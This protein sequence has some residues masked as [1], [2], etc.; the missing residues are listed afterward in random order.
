MVIGKIT[1][2]AIEQISA[3]PIDV[4]KMDCETLK[5][6]TI[7]VNRYMKTAIETF[8]DDPKSPTDYDKGMTLLITLND[9]SELLWVFYTEVKPCE[10]HISKR[11]QEAIR[12]LL[13]NAQIDAYL[14]R[15]QKEE[16]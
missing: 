13:N 9:L 4:S 5:M 16:E 8:L 10:H 14:T 3:I 1:R 12:D 11:A 15:K 2:E 6:V 7:I